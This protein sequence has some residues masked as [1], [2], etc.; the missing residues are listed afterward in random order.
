MLRCQRKTVLLLL[1][2][3][4]LIL[5]YVASV[6]ARVYYVTSSTQHFP[7]KRGIGP[8]IN[9]DDGILPVLFTTFYAS[10]GRHYFNSSWIETS[11]DLTVSRWTSDYFDYS[12]SGGTQTIYEPKAKPNAVYFDGVSRTEGNGWTFT[13]QKVIVTP[14]GTDVSVCWG[15]VGGTSGSPSADSAGGELRT[16]G[17]SGKFNATLIIVSL[18]VICLTLLWLGQTTKR[19]R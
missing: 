18:T 3:L 15:P 10:S 6:E 14:S 17:P 5:P 2:S 9:F 19:R 16:V 11:T 1:T 7:V 8:Y 13:D 12:T 4:L